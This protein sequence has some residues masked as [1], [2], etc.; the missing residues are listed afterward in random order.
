[1]RGRFVVTKELLELNLA[2]SQN[3]EMSENLDED[4]GGFKEALSVTL[5]M[6]SDDES[7]GSGGKKATQGRSSF[8]D[9]DL[10][11]G[12]GSGKSRNRVMEAG[13]MTTG[14][15]NNNLSRRKD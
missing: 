2:A 8:A 1:M 11:A 9:A 13:W 3:L 12:G 10:A 5:K 7:S 6:V 14:V 4:A 15:P